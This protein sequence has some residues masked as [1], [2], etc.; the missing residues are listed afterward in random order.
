MR[1]R[2]WVQSAGGI[3]CVAAEASTCGDRSDNSP[4]SELLW[5]IL[6]SCLWSLRYSVA[7]ITGTLISGDWTERVSTPCNCKATIRVHRVFSY[8]L[9]QKSSFYL[10]STEL[11]WKTLGA[12]KRDEMTLGPGAKTAYTFGG[13]FW[14]IDWPGSSKRALNSAVAG[15][16]KPPS[17]H[18]RP[19]VGVDPALYMQASPTVVCKFYF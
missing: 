9:F 10:T 18:P 6:P 7:F 8:F 12:S 15:C 13:L 17:L 3:T 11:E 16:M 19:M 5:A 4:A 14:I 1:S 2:D